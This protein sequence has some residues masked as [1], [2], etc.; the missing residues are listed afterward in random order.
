[1]LRSLR[2]LAPEQQADALGR[3]IQGRRASR[4]VG[5]EVVEFTML[6]RIDW[7]HGRRLLESIWK[8]QPIEFKAMYDQRQAAPATWRYSTT[9]TWTGQRAR[10]ELSLTLIWQK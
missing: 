10:S 2:R 7:F 1:M 5:V 9:G 3:R 8:R 4:R 6:E